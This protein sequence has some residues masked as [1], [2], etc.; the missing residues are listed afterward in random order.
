MMERLINIKSENGIAYSFGKAIIH[1]NYSQ[2]R[3]L[4]FISL[5][6]FLKIHFIKDEKGNVQA[7]NW[8]GMARV[9]LLKRLNNEVQDEKYYHRKNN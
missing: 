1:L 4:I 8:T 3:K 6:H 5:L 9:N 7:F 2:H